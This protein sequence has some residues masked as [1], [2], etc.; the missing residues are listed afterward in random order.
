MPG[1]QRILHCDGWV[2]QE[3]SVHTQK[4]TLG[5]HSHHLPLSWHS[6]LWLHYL[7]NSCLMLVS[8]ATG[9]VFSHLQ[10]S[11]ILQ[12]LKVSLRVPMDRGFRAGLPSC[13]MSAVQLRVFRF[14]SPS[15]SE[16]PA[17]LEQAEPGVFLRSVLEKV[18]AA[19]SSHQRQSPL[20]SCR[21][22]TGDKFA[23]IHPGVICC[24]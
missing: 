15:E 2:R 17:E 5:A 23:I 9:L 8:L 19:I 3:L 13:Q 12:A 14:S 10:H 18:L 11:V 20:T 22:P 21:S 6:A 4:C 16:L 1:T 24:C 7:S